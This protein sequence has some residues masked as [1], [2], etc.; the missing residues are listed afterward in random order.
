MRRRVSESPLT[1]QPH[2]Q[3]VAEQ[4]ATR[5]RPRPPGPINVLGTG[6][7]SGRSPRGEQAQRARR[8]GFGH[9]VASEGDGDDVFPRHR[10]STAARGDVGV[11]EGWRPPSCPPENPLQEIRRERFA[12][13]MPWSESRARR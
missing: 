12:H 5:R 4:R 10:A 1:V 8:I 6:E 9:R 11:G 3:A 7:L 2:H 13:S